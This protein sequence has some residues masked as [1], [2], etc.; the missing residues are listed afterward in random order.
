[1]A[2]LLIEA[3]ECQSHADGRWLD[4]MRGDRFA[5]AR[6]KGENIILPGKPGQTEGVFVADGLDIKIAGHVWGDGA[7]PALARAAFATSIL[8]IR[9]AIVQ[10]DGGAGK[11]VT[12]TAHPPNMALATGQTATIDAQVLR[13]T[14]PDPQGWQQ[15]YVEIDLLC[16]SDP[17]I[18]TVA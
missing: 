5:M 6:S 11:I 3:V 17:P 2:G 8:A 15:T 13:W 1:M 10:A 7:T 18:W 16:I 12:I 14:L 9:S 4:V